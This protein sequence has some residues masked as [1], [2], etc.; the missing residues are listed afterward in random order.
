VASG[1]LVGVSDYHVSTSIKRQVYV[2]AYIKLL[3]SSLSK[4]KTLITSHPNKVEAAIEDMLTQIDY[5][6]SNS[7]YY[8]NFFAL[9]TI[10]N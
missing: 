6:I 1:F 5:V 8:S 9:N 4:Y 3:T 7:M 2:R 10:L